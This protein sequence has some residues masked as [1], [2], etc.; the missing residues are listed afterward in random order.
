MKTSYYYTIS[1]K[2]QH[3]ILALKMIKKLKNLV[4]CLF[5]GSLQSKSNVC[6]SVLSPGP[7]L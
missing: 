7:E 5:S 2:F 3:I 1:M 6:F 4:Y